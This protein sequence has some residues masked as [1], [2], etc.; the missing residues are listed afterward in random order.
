MV[1]SQ[2]GPGEVLCATAPLTG[3]VVKKPKF[4][5]DKKV[6]S[7]RQEQRHEFAHEPHVYDLLSSHT[8]AT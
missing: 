1:E 2:V 3:G 8:S 4:N 5:I 6:L 7:Q